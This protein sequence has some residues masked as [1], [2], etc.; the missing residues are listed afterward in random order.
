MEKKSA[1][2]HLKQIKKKE[3]KTYKIQARDLKKMITLKTS[4]FIV[5][6]LNSIIDIETLSCLNEQGKSVDYFILYK[7]PKLEKSNDPLIKSGLQY[8]YYLSPSSSSSS[9]TT[10]WTI[11][12]R[13][14]NDSRS[15]L[16]ATL[17]SILNNKHPNYN[18]IFYNDQ[19]PS[20]M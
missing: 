13:S 10:T 6:I 2:D 11:G 17:K 20:S 3:K 7:I 8:V 18:L 16:G 15:I 12:Q 5:I 4:I 14:L 19:K 1:F 9:S